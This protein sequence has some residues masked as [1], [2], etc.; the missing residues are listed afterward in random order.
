[1]TL[2]EVEIRPSEADLGK[3]WVFKDFPISNTK[4]L[5]HIEFYLDQIYKIG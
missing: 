1:V 4:C 5:T 3:D 2:E